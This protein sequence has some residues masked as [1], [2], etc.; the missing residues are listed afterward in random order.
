MEELQRIFYEKAERDYRAKFDR[1][2][3]KGN[4]EKAPE[5]E[6]DFISLE[7]IDFKIKKQD[8]KIKRGSTRNA[9]E[10]S[11]APEW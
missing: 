5:L 7:P 3:S 6:E 10:F 2:E 4:S 9:D 8:E 1:E 11:L